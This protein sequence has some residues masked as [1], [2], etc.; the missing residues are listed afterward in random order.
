MKKA[1][2]SLPVQEQPGSASTTKELICIAR[3]EEGLIGEEQPVSGE[4]RKEA[5]IEISIPHRSLQKNEPISSS[6]LSFFSISPPSSPL[7]S[8]QHETSGVVETE[9]ES[10]IEEGQGIV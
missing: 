5:G 3:T 10:E 6:A 7:L 4:E 9:S 8:C 1:E 2:R